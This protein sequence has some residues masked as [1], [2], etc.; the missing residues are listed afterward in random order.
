MR[1]AHFQPLATGVLAGLV[2]FSSSFAVVLQGLTAVGASPTEAGSGLM[3][4]SI[5]MGLCGLI[6]SLATKLPIS[7]AWSTP[8]AA[9]LA[10]SVAPAGGF[11]EAVGAFV[12]T[13][14]LIVLTGVSPRLSRLVAKV[15]PSLAN[16]M[17]AGIL[18]SLCLAP[19]R[20]VVE[21]PLM[22]LAVV[23]TWAIV[24]VFSRLFAVPAAVAVALVFIGTTAP[25]PPGVVEALVPAPVLI[26]PSFSIAV[27]IGLA[28]PLYLVTM[29]SQN[30]PGLAVLK[31]NNYEPKPA[32]LLRVT[33]LF[34]ILGA[35]FGSHAVNLAAITAALCAGPEAG[36]DPKHRYWAAVS[37]G[38][39]YVVFGLFAGALTAFIVGAPTFLIEAVAGL[40]LL[41][42][43]ASTLSGS[44]LIPEHREAAIVTFVVSAS[45]QAF[46][47]IGAAF[48]GLFAGLVMLGLGL[49][50]I[51]A[52]KP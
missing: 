50:R 40:A 37:A 17:L 10:T 24:G 19:A 13:G 46:L 12:V 21:A 33:G 44:L 38:A 32:P 34:T 28:I 11:A 6:V 31:A 48:W 43:L 41:G 15:P 42:A 8:G 2:G 36:A 16:A 5:A 45:G 39:V 47:G 26:A 14:I 35:P 51:F 4:A 49:F 20:A 22:G 3:A 25:V 18:L 52:M 27:V 23:L 1:I 9:L 30:L 29:A 7:I